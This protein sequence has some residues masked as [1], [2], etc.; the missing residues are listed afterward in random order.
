[1]FSVRRTGKLTEDERQKK[2]VQQLLVAMG[3]SPDDFAEAPLPLEAPP[4]PDELP[5]PTAAEGADGERALPPLPP[6]DVDM[7]IDGA[8]RLLTH[9]APSG[10][11]LLCCRT[12][13]QSQHFMYRPEP[14][15]TFG[16]SQGEAFASA[17]C[18]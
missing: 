3:A 11:R 9:P 14:A 13:G 4:M 12:L 5:P 1:M 15:S 8:T 2:K 10:F 18:V 17:L 6:P 16:L 7:D